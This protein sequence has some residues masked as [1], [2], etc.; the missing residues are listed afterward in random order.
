MTRAPA[1]GTAAL[2]ALLTACSGSPPHRAAAEAGRDS[3]PAVAAKT[4]SG[5]DTTAADPAGAQWSYRLT[6][7]WLSE[8]KGYDR[9]DPDADARDYEVEHRAECTGRA[10]VHQC[11]TGECWTWSLEDVKC[12]GKGDADRVDWLNAESMQVRRTEQGWSLTPSIIGRGDCAPKM[13]FDQKGELARMSFTCEWK[14]SPG[15]PC[16]GGAVYQFTRDSLPP[17]RKR[18]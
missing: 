15:D 6:D 13:S 4:D 1:F 11:A 8:L 9:Q 10:R 12:S 7:G 18:P 3:T 2:L 5:A 17:G 16:E 14:C